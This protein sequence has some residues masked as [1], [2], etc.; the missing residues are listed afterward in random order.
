MKN[1]NILT[2]SVLLVGCGGNGGFSSST[3]NTCDTPLIGNWVGITNQDAISITNSGVFGYANVGC[4]SGGIF[5]CPGSESSGILQVNI[6]QSTGGNCLSVGE[7]NCAY[8]INGSALVYNCGNGNID[9]KKTEYIPNSGD[10]ESSSAGNSSSG[11]ES[12]IGGSISGGGNA[13]VQNTAGQSSGGISNIA[14]MGNVGGMS[15]IAGNSSSGAGGINNIAGSNSAGNSGAGGLTQLCTPT[16]C[17]DI[18]AMHSSST[19]NALSCGNIDDGCGHILNCG[20]CADV[21]SA[22]GVAN[23]T[24][25]TSGPTG[26][27]T[28]Q[29]TSMTN[30][31]ANICGGNCAIVANNENGMTVYDDENRAYPYTFLC[32]NYPTD[33]MTNPPGPNCIFGRALSTTQQ[34]FFCKA[35]NLL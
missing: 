14:G 21:Y 9:Y 6:T 35:P 16:T 2:I 20:A 31:I 27:V 22:C 30:P 11:G 33:Y 32:R 8:G 15:N 23:Y 34:L 19:Y 24:A 10:G 25:G 26:N 29:L 12:N 17:N 5:S 4:T 13:G 18:S 7:Y 28:V 1:L 3:S